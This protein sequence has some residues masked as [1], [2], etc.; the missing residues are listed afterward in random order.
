M[1]CFVFPSWLSAEF[2]E[3]MKT[4][5]KKPGSSAAYENL[6]FLSA[7][8]LISSSSYESSDALIRC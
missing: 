5:E 6:C 3:L 2:Q 1:F 8:C 4:M 7:F